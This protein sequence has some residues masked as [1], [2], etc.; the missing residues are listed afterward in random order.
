MKKTDTLLG[1]LI[2]IFGSTFII[3]TL[4]AEDCQSSGA[5]GAGICMLMW[6]LV[7]V[8]LGVVVGNLIVTAWRLYIHKSS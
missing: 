8:P 2:G 7:G 4:A 5:C 3:S 6:H 1:T